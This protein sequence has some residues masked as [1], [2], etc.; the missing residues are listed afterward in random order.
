MRVHLTL[1]DELLV[2]VDAAAAAD[3][4]D[5]S[6]AVCRLLALALRLS[7]TAPLADPAPPPPVRAR[8]KPHRRPKA[9]PAGILAPPGSPSAWTLEGGI[10]GRPTMADLEAYVAAVPHNAAP[11]YDPEME[12]RAEAVGLIEGNRDAPV[13]VGPPEY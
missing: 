8:R 1:P 3:F 2:R 6:A 7:A 10:T 11:G 12:S 9:V 5:R 13:D 4:V